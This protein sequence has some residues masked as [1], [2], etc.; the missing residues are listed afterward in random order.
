MS[1]AK[2][3]TLDALEAKSRELR[4]A[5]HR[6]VMCHGTFD[7]MHTGHIRH[8]QRAKTEG[9]ILL[10]TL[11]GDAYVNKG[12][13]RPV[14]DEG[15]R[16]ETIASLACVDFV[17]INYEQAAITAIK[18]LR[19]HVYVKGSEYRAALDDVTGN[20]TREK[21]AVEAGGGSIFYTDE[22]TFSSSSLLNEHFG[23][24]SPETKDYLQAFRRKN[25]F[26][27]VIELVK[28]LAHLKVLIVGDT[29]VD[30]Y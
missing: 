9:D 19:P 24:F 21:E 20:I 23:V 7:L 30:Q 18:R 26:K 11:T 27:D 1:S 25:G 10:V 2:I 14:F 4:D 28:G 29:I 22:I 17:A 8:L 15:L 6:I 5:G 12:P 13:G 16:A 3:L